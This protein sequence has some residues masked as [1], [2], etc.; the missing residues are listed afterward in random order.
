[1]PDPVRSRRASRLHAW[2]PSP[3]AL[4]KFS[5]TELRS[6]GAGVLNACPLTLAIPAVAR[7]VSRRLAKKKRNLGSVQ[8][9]SDTS[10]TE[11]DWDDLPEIEIRPSPSWTNTPS[12]SVL[13][14]GMAI[15]NEPR[16]G[17][18]GRSRPQ[19]VMG[20]PVSAMLHR[21]SLGG[22]T[23]TVSQ[24]STGSDSC[25]TGNAGGNIYGQEKPLASGN[26]VALSIMLAE[27]VLFLQGYDQSE[28]ANST[29]TMLR[30]SFHLRVSKAA[31][32]KAITLNFRGRAETEWP[33][34]P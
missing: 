6:F 23:R 13:D 19:S 10:D 17:G 16:G 7:K 12:L 30:G 25:P 1:M 3:A 22:N 2:T 27:P 26:G 11:P 20:G 34:G 28:L 32:I 18:G 4:H 8:F 21:P 9:T 24:N 33:E 15:P 14:V 31:K 29:T 5:N